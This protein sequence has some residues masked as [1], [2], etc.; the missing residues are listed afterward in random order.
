MFK[1]QIPPIFIGHGVHCRMSSIS[2]DRKWLD[3]EEF[4]VAG[5]TTVRKKGQKVGGNLMA[6]WSALRASNP[7]FFK[8]VVVVQQPSATCLPLIPI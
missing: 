2:D 4:T 3:D 6:H 1:G 5:H 8:D 7:Q